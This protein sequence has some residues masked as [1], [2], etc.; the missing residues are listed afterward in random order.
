MLSI[1]GIGIDAN[2]EDLGGDLT[3]LESKL[4]IFT[5]VGFDNVE[6]HIAGLNVIRGGKICKEEL[7]ELIKITRR[8]PLNY[9]CHAPNAL[10]IAGGRNVKAHLQV[11]K[12]CLYL[13]VE[14][15]AKLFV[16]HS[17]Q[18]TLKYLF[19]EYDRL[20]SEK[21]LNQRWEVETERLAE[22]AR[23]ASDLGIVIGIEN[24]DPQLSEILFLAELGIPESQLAKY[25]QALRP[26]LL[27]H[28]IRMIN[29]PNV[30]L[31]LD[32]GHAFLAVPYW[33]GKDFLTVI[34]EVA[35]QVRHVHLHDNFGCLVN[36]VDKPCERLIFGVGD[37]HLPPGWGKIP[38]IEVLTILSKVSYD[39]WL[40][41]EIRPK[42]KVV[43]LKEALRNTRNLLEAIR[44]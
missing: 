2:V 32:V 41:L 42:H 10:N 13:C 43:Y 17:G 14:V 36:G 3:K 9:T 25:N 26:D 16:Y 18:N 4:E 12:V 20:P 38:L 15:G 37:N 22:M 27:A 29:S 6:L 8:F 1:K 31:T 24:M 28:Q 30:G 33:E 34:E 11:F 7:K 44:G 39:G 35:P 40:N 23:L 21:E 5:E 19:L